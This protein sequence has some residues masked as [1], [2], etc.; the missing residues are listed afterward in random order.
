[1]N[2]KAVIFDVGGVLLESP[3]LAA[4]RWAEEWDIPLTVLAEVFGDY[5]RTV[6]PGEDPPTWHEVEC[7]RVE[8][9]DFVVQMQKT[10]LSELPPGHK[11]TTMTADDFDPFADAEPIAPMLELADESRAKGIRT[12]ILT[13][14]VREWGQWRD[15]LP[16]Q[17]FDSV[18]DSCEVGMRKP[19]PDIYVFVCN[20]LGLAPKDCLFLDDHPDNIR[21][22]LAVGLDA[23][24]VSED[25]E[26]AVVEVRSRL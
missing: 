9:S 8:L 5:A 1:M 24:L 26:A 18:V 3:F 21:G 13:N 6:E 20:Q 4:L 15:R 16:L 14:N 22:A 19:D 17:S 10:F 23:L 7:G 11:A 2:P 25:F 12:A